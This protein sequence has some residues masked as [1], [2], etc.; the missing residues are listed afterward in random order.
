MSTDQEFQELRNRVT[1][2]EEEFAEFRKQFAGSDEESKII[3]A[4]NKGDMM[5]A[6]DI[7]QT[8]HHASMIEAQRH[9]LEIKKKIG[10]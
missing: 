4:I 2:L 5:A 3:E 7:Y 6:I 1:K 10:K 8:N 9:V